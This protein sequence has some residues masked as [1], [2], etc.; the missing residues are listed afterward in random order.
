[1]QNYEQQVLPNQN[2]QHTAQYAT[3]S[4][5]RTIDQILAGNKLFSELE[6]TC[7]TPYRCEQNESQPSFVART[8]SRPA[9]YSISTSLR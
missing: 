8:P 4:P 2:T 7:Q 5:T 3:Q 1:M 9:V 6:L